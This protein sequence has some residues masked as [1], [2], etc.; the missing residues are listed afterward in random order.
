MSWRQV[1]GLEGG[2]EGEGEAGEA[3]GAAAAQAVQGVHGAPAQTQGATQSRIGAA[4]GGQTAI[5]SKTWGATL[6]E[7]GQGQEALWVVAAL[8]SLGQTQEGWEATRELPW[9]VEAL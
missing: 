2:G 7:P 3:E 5:Q 9:E 4:V 6:E 1:G 8:S